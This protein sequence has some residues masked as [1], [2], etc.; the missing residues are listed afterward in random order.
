MPSW[1]NAGRGLGHG[2]LDQDFAKARRVVDTTSPAR[3]DLIYN[4]GN[5]MRRRNAGKILITGSIAG[6]YPPPPAAFKPS[7]MEPRLSSIPSRLR[8]GGTEGH[9]GDGD[10]PSCRAPRRR[11]SSSGAGM[12]DTAVGDRLTRTMPPT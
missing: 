10:L 11:N 6:L 8:C 4:V 2:F 12:M 5:D 9:Q 7:T 1:Q 3:S